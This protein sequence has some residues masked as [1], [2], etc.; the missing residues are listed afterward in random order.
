MPF[1]FTSLF[2][3]ALASYSLQ[4][5]E[6]RISASDL[7]AD[8]IKA[9]LEAYGEAN[10]IDFIIESVG[11]LPAIDQLHSDEIDLAI[12]AVPEVDSNLREGYSTYPF[13]YDIAVV[14]V[15]ES[16]PID[17]I[18]L[19]RLGGIFGS[20]EEY[21]YNTWGELGLSGWGS[22]SIKPLAGPSEGSISLELFKHV[23][24][25]GGAMKQKVAM[26]KN[27]E[28]EEL[29]ATD[30]ASIGVLSDVP[31]NARV[32]AIMVAKNSDSPA[33]GPSEDNVHYGDYPIRLAFHIA[34]NQRD[35]E[36]LQPVLRVLFDDATAKSLRE[37]NLFALPDTIRRKFTIDLDLEN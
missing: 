2:F 28:V 10:D 18:T 27:T 37:N 1:R 12:I 35:A 19:S 20:N 3:A 9:P 7:L 33:Y 15:H 5:A 34:F 25:Q 24:F 13:A 11:S 29:I 21:N 32:K 23:V 6:I 17:E 30:A 22:R 4:A 26:V 36:K 16:N 31:T 8:F 14:V